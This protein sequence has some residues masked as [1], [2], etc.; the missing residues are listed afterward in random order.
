[1]RTVSVN[2]LKANVGRG[3]P[4]DTD[5]SDKGT[6]TNSEAR[7][8]CLAYL[9]AD[10]D[11]LE[12]NEAY[13]KLLGRPRDDL[14]EHNYFELFPD[15]VTRKVF[16]EVRDGGEMARFHAVPFTFRS[17]PGSRLWDWSL[18]P[19]KGADGRVKALVLSLAGTD[20]ESR[21]GERLLE[22]LEAERAQLTA[23]ID[24]APQGITLADLEGRILRTNPAA[25]RLYARPVPYG[26]SFKSHAALMLRRPD[27]SAYPPRDLPLTRAALDGETVMNE[28]VSIIWPDGQRRELLVNA[29]PVH[30]PSGE[31]TGAMALFQDITERKRTQDA[32]RHYAE[33]L[34]TLRKI[35]QGMLVES[36]AEAV[37]R[38][39][40]PLARQLLPVRRLS[41]NLFD[42]DAEEMQCLAV[43]TE[44]ETSVGT[45]W[46][47]PLWEE[48]LLDALRGGRPVTVKDLEGVREPTPLQEALHAERVGAYTILPLVAHD[49]LIGTFNVGLPDPR[50]LTDEETTIAQDLANQLAI[51]LHQARLH[52][53]IRK[54]A[55]NLERVVTERTTDLQT[56]EARF[57]AIFEEAAIG[58]V[59]TDLEGHATQINATMER[60]LGYESGELEGVPFTEL[61]HPDDVEVDWK[62]FTRLVAGEIDDYQIEKRYLRKD[63]KVIW[64]RLVVSTVRGTEDKPLFAVGMVEDV[65]AQKEAQEAL[66]R[67]E[68]LSL[69]G[70]LAASLAHEINNPLQTVVGCLALAEEELAKEERINRYLSMASKEID[71]AAR[72]VG[73]LRDLNRDSQPEDREPTDVCALLE[74]VIALSAQQA[75]NSH[76]RVSWNPSEGERPEISLVK[77]RLHQVFLNLILNAID[78]MAEG[79]ELEITCQG[80]EDP[81]GIQVRF[82]DTGVGVPSELLPQ[83]F[84]P[85]YTTKSDGVGL[86]LFISRNIIEDHGGRIE[87][88]SE[89]GEGTTFTV[90]LPA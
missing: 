85:F 77:D 63:G 54:H 65:S 6:K 1:M 46:R 50:A 71:R 64:G 15:P 29:A 59:V 78:A 57:R 44:G 23:L 35:D 33:R 79:G 3:K 62:L 10:F 84:E 82:K 11:F 21:L 26:D 2:E 72:I 86:G 20:A 32:L 53:E 12:V 41:V 73:E 55:V 76:V 22:Q 42:F 89:P 16:E 4:P 60:M 68:K 40:L 69:T 18:N 34:E 27:G 88:T 67:A 51:G 8:P 90:W 43:L 47:G 74:R 7:A 9:D 5:D 25:D 56:S 19:L 52:E 81:P 49:L 17:R 66:V 31:R 83:L 39:V 87:V 24:H 13:A 14:I 45:G 36:S 58:I 61:T 48:E 30:T 70:R 80:A 75:E 38:D 37:A 28:E